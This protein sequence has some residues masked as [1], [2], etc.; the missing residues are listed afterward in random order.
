MSGSQRGGD[1]SSKLREANS[2]EPERHRTVTIRWSL[3]RNLF[4]LIV[5]LTGSILLTTVYTGRSITEA[6]SRALIDR[7]LQRTESDLLRFFD[8]VQGGLRF[9]RELARNGTLD[10]ND[11]RAMNR[12]FIPLVERIPQISSVNVGDAEGRGYLLMR[13]PDRWRNRLTWTERWGDRLEYSEWKDGA[14]LLREWTAEEPPPEERYDPRTR[15]WYRVALEAAAQLEPGAAVPHE[16]Y[17]TDAYTFF[18]TGDP[19]ITAMI[20]VEDAQGNRFILA[21]DVLLRDLSGFTRQL[22]VSPNGFVFVMAD[23]G[24]V[25]GLPGLRAFDDAQ[26]RQQALLKQPRELGIASV[27]DGA[28]AF[29][30]LGPQPPP[31][32]SFTSGGER[33]WADSSP[34]RLGANRTVTVVAVVPEADLVGV[35][36]Q[37]R[38]LLLGVSLVGFGAALAMALWLAGRYS[39]PLSTLARNSQRIGSLELRDLV[40]VASSLREV[41]QLVTEQERMRVALDSFSRYV[42]MEIIR[43]LLARGEAARIG[44]SRRTITSLFT[45]VRGFTSISE[46]LSPE[47]IT[48]HMAEYFEQMLQIVQGDGYGTVTQLNG[49]GLVAFWGAPLE[50]EEH[51]AHAAEAVVRCEERLAELNPRWKE[52]GLPELPTRFGLATGPV[53]VGNVGALSRLVYTALGD[54]VNLASRLEGL[55]RFY[56]TSVLVSAPMRA[57]AGDGFAWRLVDVVRVKGKARA[58][59][60]HELLGRAA[61]VPAPTLAFAARYEE[62]LAAYR[63]RRFGE[64]VTT[65]EALDAERPDD[66]SVERLLHRARGFAAT[67]PP[68]DWDGVSDFFEK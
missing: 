1:K 22:R 21:L 45:D 4:L 68:E 28:R 14:S 24:K 37:Q 34:L 42:P 20:H 40:P 47:A 51:A 3:V 16:V 38:V 13:F 36:T 27:D 66:V 35:I 15:A 50:D 26:A 19:G 8:P 60:V 64:A 25:L 52:R 9:A 59:E 6:M 55:S 62:A 7:A 18:T 33:Y 11:A 56:G 58:V 10:V 29:R 43:E 31:I 23:D 48:A 32:F 12:L 65:L 17:W 44:G 61:G 54:T 67:S 2:A 49:D 41:D 53:V 63:G 30:A 46:A 39:H 57:A 5:L